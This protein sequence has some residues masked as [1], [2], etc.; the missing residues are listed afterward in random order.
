MIESGPK[1]EY[2]IEI[3][4]NLTS[5]NYLKTSDYQDHF[6]V[7]LLDDD[8]AISTE[9]NTVTADMLAHMHHTTED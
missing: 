4:R 8:K 2:P 5:S 7:G 6:L 1:R 9:I 3:I